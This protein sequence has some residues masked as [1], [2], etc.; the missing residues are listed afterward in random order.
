MESGTENAEEIQTGS[1]EASAPDQL[2]DS[3]GGVSESPFDKLENAFQQINGKAPS[4]SEEPAGEARP[5]G[6]ADSGEDPDAEDDEVAAPVTPGKVKPVADPEESAEDLKPPRNFDAKKKEKFNRMPKWIRREFNGLVSELRGHADK[7]FRD[8]NAEKG[9][10]GKLTEVVEHHMPMWGMSNVHPVEAIDALCRAQTKMVHDPVG[11]LW[12]QAQAV[13]L[14]FEVLAK[15]QRGEIPYK[16]GAF[17][18]AERKNA[19]PPYADVRAV[20]QN[21]MRQANINA[22]SAAIVSEVDQAIESLQSERDSSGTSYVYP[23]LHDQA[24]LDSLADLVLDAKR[25][26]PGLSYRDAIVKAWSY[27]TGRPAPGPLLPPSRPTLN[28]ARNTKNAAQITGSVRGRPFSSGAGGFNL[29]DIP[30]EDIPECPI[31]TGLMV[32]RF[33]KTGRWK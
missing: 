32:D 14:D 26:T 21:E 16:P 20:V 31:E 30:T 15:I 27:R 10:W 9:K 1:S 8:L 6:E 13:G 4:K 28:G 2:P 7:T 23:E 18:P 19:A 22:Q 11:G 3:G 33:L 17:Q 25:A 5:E 29:N 12:D 24:F